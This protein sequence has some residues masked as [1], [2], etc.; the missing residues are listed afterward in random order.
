MHLLALAGLHPILWVASS[1]GNIQPGLQPRPVD[2]PFFISLD[3]SGATHVTMATLKRSSHSG[4][5]CVLRKRLH[6]GRG[7]YVTGTTGHA[8]KCD[9]LKKNQVGY[10]IS[11]NQP[12][13]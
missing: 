12:G 5:T 2:Q 3:S 9:F 10:F 6:G 8:Q 13:R 1:N 7:Q 11:K 4:V